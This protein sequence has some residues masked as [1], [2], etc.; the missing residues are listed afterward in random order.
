MNILNNKIIH[1][2]IYKRD[3]GLEGR[4][5]RGLATGLLCSTFCFLA[6][7]EGRAL[8]SHHCLLVGSPLP[9]PPPPLPLDLAEGK[10]LQPPTTG[11]A[12]WG[13]AA[14]HF[15]SSRWIWWRGGHCRCVHT[16]RKR[17][18]GQ[19]KEAGGCR[20]EE[21]ERDIARRVENKIWAS[22]FMRLAH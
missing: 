17:G 18:R 2:N 3:W 8:R 5:G 19:T 13:A 4:G 11:S 14:A 20:K 12:E 7:G 10:T 6:G 1:K 21:E 9:L 16:E 22:F 15:L